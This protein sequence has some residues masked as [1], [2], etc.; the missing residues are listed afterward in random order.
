MKTE[1]K[2]EINQHA[3]EEQCHL[4]SNEVVC[5]AKASARG[6]CQYHYSRFARQEGRKNLE[7]YS[8]PPIIG[9]PKKRKVTSE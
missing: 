4:I 2:Y 8:L 5:P 7:K 3:T 1:I 6:L 9:N